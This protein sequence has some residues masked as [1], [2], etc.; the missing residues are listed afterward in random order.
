MSDYKVTITDKRKRTI[1]RE[2]YAESEKNA[3]ALIKKSFTD[4]GVPI[5]NLKFKAQQS[6]RIS[7][8]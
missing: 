5:R 6:G 2:V 1:Q 3:I 8:E 7:H 4:Y